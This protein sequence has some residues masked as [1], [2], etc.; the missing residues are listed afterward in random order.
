MTECY[1]YCIDTEEAN[2]KLRN[3][4]SIQLSTL[5]SEIVLFRLRWPEYDIKL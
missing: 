3:Q 4:F 2:D 1:R 5:V